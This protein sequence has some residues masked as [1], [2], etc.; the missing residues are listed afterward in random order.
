M[1]TSSTN[2]REAAD[3]AYQLHH[4]QCSLC[5]AAGAQP[6]KQQRCPEGAPLWKAYFDAGDLPHFTWL[7]RQQ[8]LFTRP[9][10]QQRAQS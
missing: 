7:H 8:Q 2:D 4:A 1:T 3:K 9:P 6:G 10:I 5:R